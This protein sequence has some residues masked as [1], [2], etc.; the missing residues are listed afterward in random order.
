MGTAIIEEY[1]SLA[2]VG[3]GITAQI[4]A[5]PLA[6]QKITTSGTTARNSVDFN[7]ATT[8]VVISSDANEHFAVGGSGVEADANDRPLYANTLRE[9][10][11]RSTD[12]RIAFINK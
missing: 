6:V 1:A 2:D 3:G 10:E 11:V 7:S 4:P 12:V 5:T 9:V 8:F